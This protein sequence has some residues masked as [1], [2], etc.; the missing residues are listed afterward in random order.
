VSEDLKEP[1]LSLGP[2]APISGIAFCC[3]RRL[4]AAVSTPVSISSNSRRV[5][6]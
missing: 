1:G 2:S 4:R 3:A 6:R 5:I